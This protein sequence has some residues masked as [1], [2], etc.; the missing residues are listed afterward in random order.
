[1]ELSN[2]EIR[3]AF[4]KVIRKYRLQQGMKQEELEEK[5]GLSINYMSRIESGKSGL[6]NNKLIK[7]MNILNI[8]PNILYKEAITDNELQKQIEISEKISQMSSEKMDALLEII[9]ILKKLK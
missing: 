5:L 4:G 7:C 8:T 9:E 6:A 1:M 2:E 3:K